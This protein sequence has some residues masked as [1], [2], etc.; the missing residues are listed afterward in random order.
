MCRPTGPWK[1]CS[2]A[3]FPGRRLLRSTR[4]TSLIGTSSPLREKRLP[5]MPLTARPDWFQ[6]AFPRGDYKCHLN[7]RLRSRTHSKGPRTEAKAANFRVDGRDRD[8]YQPVRSEECFHSSRC[9]R[10]TPE[11]DEECCSYPV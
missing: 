9:G 1:Q 6:S 7:W 5:A 11:P 3:A 4:S 2:K 8:D 10:D